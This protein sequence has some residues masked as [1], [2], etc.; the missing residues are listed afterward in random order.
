[1][2]ESQ[3][4]ILHVDD[5]E[6]NRYVITR[7][8]QNAGLTVVEAATGAEGLAEIG[9]HGPD[10]VILDVNLPD[11][12]GFEICRQIKS[13]PETAMIPCCISR[14]LLSKVNIKL[15]GWKVVLIGI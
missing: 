14:L 2:S 6:T 3:A 15:K 9:R 1:M 8:L 4:T 7:I 12:N 10:L 11:F 13:N 5:N